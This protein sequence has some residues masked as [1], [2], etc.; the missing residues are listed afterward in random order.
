MKAVVF[1]VDGLDTHV[2]ATKQQRATESLESACLSVAVSDCCFCV[3]HVA[4][5]QSKRE[6]S[7]GAEA[8]ADASAE[9]KKKKKD[10]K[11]D[12]GSDSE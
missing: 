3:L 8:A 9:K 1:N 4:V 5:L 6:R 10:K 2:L 7:P 12:K 11:K